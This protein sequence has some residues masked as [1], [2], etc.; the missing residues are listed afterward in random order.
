MFCSIMKIWKVNIYFNGGHKLGS[1]ERMGGW[2]RCGENRAHIRSI[3]TI[4]NSS[5]AR[6][7]IQTAAVK[8]KYKPGIIIEYCRV[9]PLTET[10]KHSRLAAAWICFISGF[11]K[12]H[13]QNDNM[14]CA[15]EFINA[16]TK[17]DTLV[18]TI[19]RKKT[20]R[21]AAGKKIRCYSL[22]QRKF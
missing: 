15:R 7:N 19:H 14:K 21:K 11:I 4:C 3:Y 22:M 6:I 16:S 10:Q 9:K 1:V 8:K 17:I 5:K 20:K 2:R 12:I 13:P 18:G